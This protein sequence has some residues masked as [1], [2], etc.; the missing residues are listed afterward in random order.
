M[1][2]CVCGSVNTLVAKK[3]T[4]KVEH[5]GIFGEIDMHYSECMKCGSDIS[6]PFQAA[7]NN[8]YME[9]FKKSVNLA[10]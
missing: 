2:E 6:N 9:E 4:N 7:M 8:F 1:N 3:T 10:R 5:N